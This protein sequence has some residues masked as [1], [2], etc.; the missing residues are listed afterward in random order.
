M[1]IKNSRKNTSWK[2]KIINEGIP[3][4]KG[5]KFCYKTAQEPGVE[6]VILKKK[7]K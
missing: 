3:L 6:L 5:L 4:I 1:G 7:K 2:K